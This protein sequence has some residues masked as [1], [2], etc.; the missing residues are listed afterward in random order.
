MGTDEQPTV[1]NDQKRAPRASFVGRQLGDFKITRL[2]GRG[3]M[4]EV[5]LAEQ[6][7]LHR[8]VALKILKSVLAEDESYLRRFHSEAKAV[9][10]INHP[11]IVAVIAIGEH[12]GT[13]YMALEYVQGRNLREYLAKKGT[14]SLPEC[15]SIMRKVAA[16]LER[17]H[18]EGI[19]HRDIKPENVL[20]TKKGDVKVAD[21]GLARQV[22]ED[23]SLT[24]SGVTMGTPLYM[25][26]EQVQ[27]K[28]LDHRTDIYSFGVMCYHMMAGHPPYMGETAM[29]VAVQHVN[30]T[31]TD[32]STL[33]PDMP[34]AMTAII[35]KMMAKNRNKRYQSASEVLS[36]LAKLRSTKRVTAEDSHPTVPLELGEDTAKTVKT[37]TALP[38][39]SRLAA[40]TETMAR[41]GRILLGPGARTWT[42]TISLLIALVAGVA[43]G[44]Q[45]R[46]PDPLKAR[47]E[48]GVAA[49]KPDLSNIQKWRSGWSQLRY[50]RNALSADQREQGLWSVIEWHPGDERETIDAAQELMEMYLSERKYEMAL[51]LAEHLIKCQDGQEQMIG[52]L[53]KGIVYSR[54]HDFE[55]SWRSFD[56]MFDIG[57]SASFRLDLEQ[58][59][60]LASQ[61]FLALDLNAQVSGN[62]RD[63]GMVDRFWK[64]FLP[65]QGRPMR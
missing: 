9:A 18:D 44:W 17:A 4:G 37:G 41:T 53:F 23:V 28:K 38:T 25:S 40:I 12:E 61:Y 52:H 54:L 7:S 33:R 64:V 63:P 62:K 8:N 35:E 34:K 10:P 57:R 29:A 19:V 50:A 22:S 39:L 49:T 16:A 14:L 56:A 24:Q 13:H 65:P 2:L 1:P 31:P 60:W 6:L 59:R 51:V 45:G 36:D 26:P 21:F 11:N 27:G 15:A 47:Q 43:V 42:V 3:G 20:L 46:E 5:Y 55:A 32:L 30:G 48:Q 58:Q